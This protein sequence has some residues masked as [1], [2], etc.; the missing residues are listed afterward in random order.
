MAIPIEKLIN[1][2]GNIYEVVSAV[3]KRSQQITEVRAAYNPTTLEE[4]ITPVPSRE[5]KT[6][7]NSEN[8]EKA[9]S[10]AFREILQKEVLY[11][12]KDGS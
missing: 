1:F 2:K 3:I 10:A 7:E 12:F 6:N 11:R 5:E 4:Q 9:T 8:K